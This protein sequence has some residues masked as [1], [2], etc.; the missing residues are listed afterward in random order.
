MFTF[1]SILLMTC[2]GY[3]DNKTLKSDIPVQDVF[4]AFELTKEQQEIVNSKLDEMITPEVIDEAEKRSSLECEVVS[5]STK[6]DRKYRALI[7]NDYYTYS[8][9]GEAIVDFSSLSDKGVKAKIFNTVFFCNITKLQLRV[10]KAISIGASSITLS[11]ESNEIAADNKY[12]GKDIVIIGVISSITQILGEPV[13]ILDG[14]N[15][16]GVPIGVY[17][18][19]RKSEMEKIA[20]LR[21]YQSV[22][23]LAV[24]NGAFAGSAK[25]KDGIILGIGL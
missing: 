17:V 4:G 21:K 25:L 22:R 18:Y 6:S 1:F 8:M 11:Y 7:L 9:G 19:M 12:K 14:Y 15:S 20:N 13:V 10:D 5:G 3:A 2:Q 24:G 16:S 23:I